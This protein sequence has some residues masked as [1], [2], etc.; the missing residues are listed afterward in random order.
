M[1]LPRSTVVTAGIAAASALAASGITY[2]SA[3]SVPAPQSAPAAP[4]TSPLGGNA[5]PGKG[6][7]GG[8]RGRGPGGWG[9]EDW[10]RIEI[11]ERSYSAHPG[12]CVT[13]IS[14]LGARTLNIRNDSRKTV[15]VFRGVVCDNGAPVATVGPRSSAE[16]V[17]VGH[18]DGIRIKDGVVASFR[19]VRHFDGDWDGGWDGGWN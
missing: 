14:G 11:N 4:A 8:N 17:R 16:G 5:G 9:H 6:N 3:A 2:A 15:E 1:K 10:G 12:D 18:V 7:E 13:V 19:V